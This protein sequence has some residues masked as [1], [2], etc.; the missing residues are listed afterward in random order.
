MLINPNDDLEEIWKLVTYEIKRG[1]IDRKHPF[2]FVVL[3]TGGHSRYVVLRTV[4]SDM[5]LL[6]Y[7]D[8]RSSK[9]NQLTSN[10]QA[11]VL[12]YHPQKRAQVIVSGSVEVHHKDEMAQEHWKNVQGEAQKSYT[13]VK[14]PGLEV[15]H[16]L[17]AYEWDDKFG[18]KYFGVLRLQAISIEILQLNTPRHLRAKFERNNN[19]EGKWLVP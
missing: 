15:E 10:P 6:F 18:P 5:G 17:E 8:M 13:S 3:T 11:Q 4:D 9:I 14:A 7:T 19:W 1:A 16:P 2:R 12:L